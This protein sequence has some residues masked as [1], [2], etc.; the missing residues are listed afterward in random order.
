M[1][2]ETIPYPT[3]PA[4]GLQISG[5][6]QKTQEGHPI[7]ASVPYLQETALPPDHIHRTTN[8][9]RIFWHAIML[10]LHNPQ[11]GE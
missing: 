7:Q 3:V 10:V 2:K 6:P 4:M 11:R 9:E 1:H 5:P 8:H